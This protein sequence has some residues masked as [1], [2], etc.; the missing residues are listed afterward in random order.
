MI[1]EEAEHRSS[2][3]TEKKEKGGFKPTGAQEKEE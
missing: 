2:E 1:S 3:V